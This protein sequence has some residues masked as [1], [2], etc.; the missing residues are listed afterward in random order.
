MTVAQR[1]S[2]PSEA[3][4][5]SVRDF[6]AGTA[7]MSRAEAVA[8]SREFRRAG[9]RPNLHTDHDFLV[10]VTRGSWGAGHNGA[11]RQIRAQARAQAAALVSWP[12]R[13]ALAGALEAAALAVLSGADTRQ[14]L[15]P[16]LCARLTA[17]YER[18]I[19]ALVPQQR[20]AVA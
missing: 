10:A 12:R 13:A 9:G 20:G 5:A 15:P 3:A 16:T 6:F 14:P 8:L 4:L 2:A 19:G 18:T 1:N 17:P 11:A 7:A